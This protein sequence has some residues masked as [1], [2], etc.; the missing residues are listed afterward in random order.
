[1]LRKEASFDTDRKQTKDCQNA[2]SET[3]LRNSSL[4]VSQK[5]D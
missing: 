3:K 4:K 1:V 2:G 5:A